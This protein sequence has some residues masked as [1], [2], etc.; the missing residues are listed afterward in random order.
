RDNRM[1]RARDVLP[2]LVRVDVDETVNL[3]GIR[4]DQVHEGYTLGPCPPYG[5]ATTIRYVTLRSAQG[6][7]YRRAPLRAHPP[8]KRAESLRQPD[9][10]A[11]VLVRTPWARR[12]SA[13]QPEILSAEHMLHPQNL[14]TT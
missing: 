7:R 10:I 1:S 5:D 14:K 6:A 3:L 13:F 2:L 11:G 12:G 4:I 8:F 9:H